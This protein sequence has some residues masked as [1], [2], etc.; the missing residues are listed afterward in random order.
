MTRFGGAD[1]RTGMST[2]PTVDSEPG[3]VRTRSA[4]SRHRCSAPSSFTLI[5]STNFANPWLASCKLK[6]SGSD[7]PY[8]YSR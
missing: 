5:T 3:S 4:V 8:R 7:G 1:L 2:V 6:R